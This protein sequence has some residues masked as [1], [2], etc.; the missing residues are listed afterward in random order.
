[1][2]AIK[3]VSRFKAASWHLL[4]SAAIA[5]ATLAIMLALW[6]PPP[7]FQAM[8]GTELAILIVGVDVAIG[9]LLTL[10]IFDTK[11]KELVF[12]L[13]VIAAIQLAALCYGIYAMHAGRPAF[14]AFVE[15]RFAVVSAAELEPEALANARLPEFRALSLTGPKL[16]A[17]DMPS[18][19]KEVEAIM[20]A[21]TMGL[22]AQHLPKYYAPY[23]ERRQM[24]VSAA[25]PLS[26]LR[27]LTTEETARLQD[28]VAA[29]KAGGRELRYLP[30]L[31]KLAILT[32]LTDARSG[33]LV[34][35]VAVNPAKE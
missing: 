34:E 7:L 5:A 3:A 17:V 26:G 23:T 4:I 6:Y 22:G 9:P 19:P 27:N 18:D 10:I 15:N 1:M 35:I 2:I 11:K 29:A 28:A 21:S 14:I 25:R 20:L 24:V 33:E 12:D 32:A 30:V 16:V 13:A 31:T 8:G